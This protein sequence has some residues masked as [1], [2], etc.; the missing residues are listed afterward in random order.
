MSLKM[1]LASTVSAF[2]LILG[3]TIMGVFAA[4]TATINLGGS[5][6]FKATDV[7]ATVQGKITGSK[8]AEA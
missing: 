5:I 2:L 4:P 7:H 3:L 8:E 1:K 6:S